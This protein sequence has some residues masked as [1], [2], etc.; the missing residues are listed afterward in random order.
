MGWN[1][2]PAFEP[3]IVFQIKLLGCVI[4]HPPSTTYHLY[5]LLREVPSSLAKNII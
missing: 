2:T 4:S 1:Q 5:A 3:I